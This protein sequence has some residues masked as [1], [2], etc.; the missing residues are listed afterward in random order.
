M[1]KHLHLEGKH[2]T[3]FVGKLEAEI[4]AVLWEART[5]LTTQAIYKHINRELAFT[6]VQTTITRMW[7]KGLIKRNKPPQRIASYQAICTEADFIDTCISL[8]IKTLNDNYATKIG[9]I[10]DER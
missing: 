8:V 6:T 5:P 9:E 7:R 4:L 2:L 1:I 10:I 3:L